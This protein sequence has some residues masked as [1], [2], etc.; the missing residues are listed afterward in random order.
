MHGSLPSRRWRTVCT[1]AAVVAGALV[2]AVGAA[3]PAQAA[4]PAE[5]EAPDY[6]SETWADP[7]DY[8]NPEDQNTDFVSDATNVAVRDGHLHFDAKA[9]TA[10]DPV[11]TVPGELAYGRNGAVR[12]IDTTRYS[13]LSFRLDQPSAGLGAVY[14]FTCRERLPSCAGGVYINLQPG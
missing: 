6:A 9:G 13:R 11:L 1:A 8:S 5:L 12:P 2:P 7:L 14:W 3:T 10:F 4:A